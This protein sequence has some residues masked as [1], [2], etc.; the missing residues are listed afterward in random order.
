[1]GMTLKELATAALVVGLAACSH[2]QAEQY[3]GTSAAAQAP[4][5]AMLA[6]EHDVRVALGADA[7]ADRIQALQDACIEGTHGQCTVLDVSRQGG[8]YPNGRLIVRVVPE[9]V[10]PLIGMAGE[11]GEVGTR[12]THAEDLAVV[13][14]D[15]RQLVERLEGERSQLQAFQQ[16]RDLS[17][18][19]MIALSRQIAEVEAQLQ[20]AAQQAAQHDL[21]INT[22]KLSIHL[23]PPRGQTGRSEIAEAVRDFG[24]TLSLGTAWTIRA[25]AFL[26]PVA[27]LALALA[28]GFRAWRRRRRARRGRD[29]GPG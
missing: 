6:Y 12:R 7:I 17:V 21:R 10:E 5:G 23:E 13:V 19:D 4:Q 20:A 27:L 24:T 18:A 16:R 25:S 22:Q 29:A 8:D 3:A 28:A 15:N 1:M 14:R 9:G 26:I 11:G 2:K